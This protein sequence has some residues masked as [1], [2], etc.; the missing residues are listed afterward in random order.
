MFFR[1]LDLLLAFA[2]G[3]SSRLLFPCLVK[4]G[5]VGELDNVVTSSCFSN[6]YSLSSKAFFSS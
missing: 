6:P 1:L 3:V 4:G 2:T 5:V